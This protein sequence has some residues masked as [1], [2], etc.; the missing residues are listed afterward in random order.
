MW[1]NYELASRTK[2]DSDEGRSATLLTCIGSETLDILD[3]LQFDSE[4]DRRKV[5]KILDKLEAY[6][7]GETNETWERFNFNKRNQEHFESV[8]T[9]VA[10]LRTL[11]KTCN[12][13]TLEDSLIR[14]RM[15]MGICDNSTRKR[16]LQSS[17]LSLKDCIDICRSHERAAARLKSLSNTEDVQAISKTRGYKKPKGK[18]TKPG[19]TTRSD[20]SLQ[21][22]FCGRSHVFNRKECPAWGRICNKCKRP[23]HFAYV[24]QSSQANVQ[25]LSDEDTEDEYILSVDVENVNSVQLHGE[26]QQYLRKI[27]AVLLIKETEVKFQLDCGSTVN[28]LPETI[29]ANVFQDPHLEKLETQVNTTLRMYNGVKSQTVGKCEVTVKNPRNE[30]EYT[31]AFLITRDRGSPPILGAIAVQQMQLITVNFENIFQISG[32]G[33]VSTELARL[34]LTDIIHRYK[35]VFEGEGTLDGLLRFEVDE[36]VTPVQLPCRKVP[37][38]LQQKLKA[39]LERLADLKII[40][41]VNVP[42]DWISALLVVVKK[43]G[44]DKIRICI[45]PKPLNQALKRNHYPIKTIDDILPELSNA[46]CFTLADAKNGFWHIQLEEKSSFLTTFETPWGRYRWLRMPFGLSPAPEEF[47]RRLN[48]AICGLD[49]V[50]AVHD[51]VLI[52]GV[53]DTY[54]VAE[55]DHDEKLSKFLDRCRNRTIKLNRS[56]LKLTEVPYLGHVVT[57]DGLKIDH[58]KVEAITNMPTPTD[59]QGIKRILGMVNFVQKFVPNLSEVTAPL[60]DLLKSDVNFRWDEQVHGKCLEKNQTYSV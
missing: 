60:R 6:C 16:L 20:Q 21:C 8:D 46:K 55:A 47:Q 49:G 2:T 12:Y 25:L 3:G 5:E 22:K 28:V 15:V 31:I 57:S 38:A 32:S 53:G 42:T 48:E 10:T 30:G 14:D 23:N 4:N 37:F 45:D 43:Q 29:Y 19:L 18:E 50:R 56:K 40:T 54:E 51:D 59:K 39:E 24:C 13:G 27:F 33:D 44:T 7:I 41:P 35:D 9:Y 11:A 26:S 34:D 17:N 58:M 52:Y 1:G 36:T